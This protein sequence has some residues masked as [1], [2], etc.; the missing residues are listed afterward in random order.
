M[1]IRNR[2]E[3]RR[4]AGAAVAANTGDPRLTVLVYII[5]TT[6][7][8]LLVSILSTVLDKRI[9]GT[10]GLQN[11]GQQAIL[12]TIQTAAPL[13]LSLVLIGLDLGRQ[14]VCLRMAR[15]RG[16]APRDLLMGFPRFGALLRAMLLQGGLYLLLLIAAANV[17]S[18]IFAF[19]PLSG[20]LNALISQAA[21]DSDALYNALYNDPEFLDQVLSAVLPAYPIMLG[22]FLLIAVPF[23]YR[24][25][26]TNYCL[27]DNPGMGAMA[28]MAES[29][30]MTRGRRFQL[31]KLDLGFWWFYLALAACSIVMY[32]DT[33]LASLGVALPWNSTTSFYIFYVS[34]LVLEGILY[35]FAL[36]RVQTTYALAYEALRP[37]PKQGG[38]VLGNIFDL[39]REHNE[40]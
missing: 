28:A 19:T 40:P 6:L 39:A 15:R 33:I 2:R 31:F 10:G 8:S 22:L 24:Y 7:S 4:E 30:R 17:G 34:A 1:D 27:L 37:Q 29:S 32:G 35:Y 23:F 14:G 36:N 3:L 26:M 20:E 5:A 9:A 11:L 25:R 12:S 13:V 38:V 16:V 18:I 21:T